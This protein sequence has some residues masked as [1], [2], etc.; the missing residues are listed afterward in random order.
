LTRI[1]SFVWIAVLTALAVIPT[2]AAQDGTQSGGYPAGGVAGDVEN[3]L[4]AVGSGAA[5]AGGQ[6]PFTG[7]NLI[8]LVVGGV[9]LLG[10]G[11]LLVVRGRTDGKS[12]A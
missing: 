10:L 2:A 8:I 9:V 12:A 7:V 4:G 11:A 1:T 6:L 5:G 3:R